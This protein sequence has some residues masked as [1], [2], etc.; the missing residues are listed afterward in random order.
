MQ[1]Q[2]GT[3]QQQT[4]F[5]QEVSERLAEHDIQLF[6]AIP[7]SPLLRTLGLDEVAAALDP[8]QRVNMP[9]ISDNVAV[10]HVRPSPS[11]LTCS[12]PMDAVG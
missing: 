10:Q 2:Q 5:K 4:A 12:L 9:S 7:R 3:E 8:C 6:G 1:V 11:C